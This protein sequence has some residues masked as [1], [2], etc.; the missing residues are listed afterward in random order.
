MN[1]KN[2]RTKRKLNVTEL[3]TQINNII[4]K[5]YTIIYI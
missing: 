2:Y 1:M 4:Y 3:N 5:L